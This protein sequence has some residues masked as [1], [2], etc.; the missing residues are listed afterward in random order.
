MS[1]KLKATCYGFSMAL[2]NAPH[3]CKGWEALS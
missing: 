2:G 1:F 3:A